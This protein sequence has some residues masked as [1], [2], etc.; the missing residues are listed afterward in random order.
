[1]QLYSI[2]RDSEHF[3]YEFTEENVIKGVKPG[4]FLEHGRPD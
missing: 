1:M 4:R 2:W 3:K